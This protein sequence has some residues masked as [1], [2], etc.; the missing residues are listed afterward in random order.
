MTQAIAAGRIDI[1]PDGTVNEQGPLTIA[2]LENP[3]R[4]RRQAHRDDAKSAPPSEPRPKKPPKQP[5]PSE[6]KA[7]KPKKSPKPSEPGAPQSKPIP[8]LARV[9]TIQ[10]KLDFEGGESYAEAERRKMIA[11]A[12]QMEMKNKTLSGEYVKRSDVQAVFFQLAAIDAKQ[13]LTINERVADEVCAIFDSDDP[14]KSAK[15]RELIG[16]E[17]QNSLKQS[18]VLMTEWLQQNE[19]P[20]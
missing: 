9:P 14:G 1:N 3:K 8:S 11:A 6:P 20:A 17:L 13:T 15:V 4:Q 10:P 19:E 16:L 7:A 12:D 5:A 18:K 2:Y